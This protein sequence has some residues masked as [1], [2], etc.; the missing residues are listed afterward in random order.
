MSASSISPTVVPRWQIVL[1]FLFALFVFVGVG[2]SAL[3]ESA[4][5][6]V[7]WFQLL[8]TVDVAPYLV[9]ILFLLLLGLWQFLTGNRGDTAARAGTTQ[10]LIAGARQP[11]SRWLLFVGASLWGI[12]IAAGFGQSVQGLPPAFH[13][14]YSYLVQAETFL[15]GKLTWPVPPAA[16]HFHQVH[17]L[18]RDGIIASRYFPAVGAWLA[19]FLLFGS[20]VWGMWLAHGL[21]TGFLAIAASRVSLL[22]GAIVGFWVGASAGLV[23]FG[24]TLLSP[25]VAVMG[26]AVSWW[27]YQE[28]LDSQR[29]RFA[30]IAGLAI[31]WAF[32]AR[33]LTAVAIT[34]PWG[35][36]ALSQSLIHRRLHRST[37]ITLI[38]GF[39][40]GPVLMAGYNFA[41]TGSPLVTPY[42]QYTAMYTP[43]HVFGF[44]NRTRGL[45]Q[46]T[47]ET[48]IAYDDWVEE[49]TPESSAFVSLTRWRH[50]VPWIAG[51][52]PVALF[53]CLSILQ[54]N[55][56]GDR[57][58]LP[59]LSI[60]CLTAIHVP[61]FYGGIFGWSYLTEG[62]PFLLFAMGIATAMV[63]ENYWRIAR[64]VTALC[65]LLPVLIAVG[66]SLLWTLPSA[67]DPASEWIY[68]RR[69]AM[70]RI[71]FEEKL[72]QPC[73]ILYD[74]DPKSDLHTTWVFNHPSFQGPILRA[75]K[76]KDPNSLMAAFPGRTVFEYANGQYRRIK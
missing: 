49:L 36:Y 72:Q 43:S 9:W 26:L 74:V 22:A 73:L 55:A 47:D 68:P 29:K 37:L 24:N 44:Y 31:A 46:R 14:E 51:F 76:G 13:D 60:F 48:Q 53:G 63:C 32:L 18:D 28:T 6:P 57:L 50:A 4:T 19:P 10:A 25:T 15:G 41:I 69:K 40:P 8:T 45:A 70:E 54:V 71:V 67:F 52:I 5:D 17:V 56:L 1:S 75:W 61:F 12:S 42:G 65:W 35:L 34:G 59:W 7:A 62:A 30:L 21:T 39:L 20:P 38:I 66:G 64:P 33:P 27:A 23:V 16:E 3:S 11:R 58:L 2:I